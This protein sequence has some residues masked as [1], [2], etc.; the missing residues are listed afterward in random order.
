MRQNILF[1]ILL[2]LGWGIMYVV[3]DRYIIPERTAMQERTVNFSI[4]ERTERKPEVIPAKNPAPLKKDSSHYWKSKYDSIQALTDRRDTSKTADSIRAEYFYPY[5]IEVTDSLTTNY[6]TIFPLNPQECRARLDGT[7]YNE[8]KLSFTYIDTTVNVTR[9][10]KLRTY[11]T[12]GSGAVIGAT[13]GGIP[14]AGIGALAALVAE[15][16]L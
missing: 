16:F 10:V 7:K 1:V 8:I 2:F 11:V 9:G 6:V 3:M 5:Q 14:G 4:A 15:E 13:F 12:V